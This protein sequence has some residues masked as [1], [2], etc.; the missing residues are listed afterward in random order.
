MADIQRAPFLRHLRGIPTTY[1]RHQRR[2]RAVH[3]GVGLAFWF[4]PL[5]A[6][7]SEV[8]V[9]DRELPLI[10]HAR[11]GDFQDV[12]VQATVTY[13][14]ADP[15]TAAS[16]LDFSIDPDR[17]RWRSSPLEQVAAQLTELAQQQALDLLAGMSLREAVS[18]KVTEVRARVAEGL[19]G[20]RRLTQ[21]GI[22]VVGVRI[23]AI[24]PEPEVERALQTP[25]REL[26][27]QEAD[28]ATYERRAIAVERERAIAENELQSQIELALRE[29]RLVGQRG[30]NERRR[31]TD[32]A[33]AAWIEAAAADRRERLAAEALAHR[34]RLV[35][36][37]DAEA[38]AARATVYR[39]LPPV[40]LLAL[41]AG[42]LAGVLPEIGQLNL[43]PDLLTSAVA[44]L[45]S[46]G[47]G[48]GE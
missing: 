44:R 36:T 45:V 2:G 24:R 30:Q 14:I 6:V 11:T 18:G 37:A 27:Q 16:R 25:A 33:A 26:V 34:S 28:A 5:A 13:R 47:A 40:A 48:G 38:Q 42:E 9:D 32:A 15:A 29:E 19:A 23:V 1:V 41:T 17:G 20:E 46:A 7:I 21:V 35:G 8:P 4:R 39:D 43:S 22:E 31:V 3:E 12:T 10:F